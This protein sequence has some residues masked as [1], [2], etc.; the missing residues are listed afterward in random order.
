LDKNLNTVAA[1]FLL[2]MRAKI[3]SPAIF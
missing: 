2:K 1:V 3:S